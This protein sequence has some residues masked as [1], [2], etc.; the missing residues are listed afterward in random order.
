[1]LFRSAIDEL[2]R[3]LDLPVAYGAMEE[4]QRIRWL[5]EEL[6]TRRPLVPPAAR[7]SDATGETLQVF[8]MLQRLQQAMRDRFIRCQ[9]QCLAVG[10]RLVEI[11]LGQAGRLE[12]ITPADVTILSVIIRA[13]E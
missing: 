12:G 7:W 13:M 2:S 3:Y 4:E 11:A 5:L 8:R 10:E 9:Q 1:M 6:Q